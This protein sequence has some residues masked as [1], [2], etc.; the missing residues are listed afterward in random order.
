MEQDLPNGNLLTSLC[1]ILMTFSPLIC[2]CRRCIGRTMATDW[3]SDCGWTESSATW[4]A[5]RISRPRSSV[6]WTRT[7]G[8]RSLRGS[9]AGSSGQDPVALQC[10]WPGLKCYFTSGADPVALHLQLTWA[11]VLLHIRGWPISF[12]PAVHLGSCV[13]WATEVTGR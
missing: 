5:S 11:K 10:S 4:Q 6:P 9:S 7:C 8:E 13:W 2:C 3:S 1:S 12:T